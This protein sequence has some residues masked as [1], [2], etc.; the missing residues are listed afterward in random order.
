M[1]KTDNAIGTDGFEFVEFACENPERLQ[2]IFT[3]L[4]F[5]LVG[6]HRSKRVF[7]VQ[8]KRHSFSD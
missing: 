6:K 4:G 5:N 8:A 1:S 3:N 7:A 2:G